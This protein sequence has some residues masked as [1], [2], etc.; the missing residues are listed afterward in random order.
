[1]VKILNKYSSSIIDKIM[2]EFI[3]ELSVNKL[4]KFNQ[5]MFINY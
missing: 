5:M 3:D 1:M 4:S 2:Q